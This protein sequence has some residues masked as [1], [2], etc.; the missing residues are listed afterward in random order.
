MTF[1]LTAG[2]AHRNKVV[3]NIKSE[4]R[5]KMLV[6]ISGYWDYGCFH[7]LYVYVFFIFPF[8]K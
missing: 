8:K 5:D 6:I 3:K 1:H 2:F 7:F 4:K